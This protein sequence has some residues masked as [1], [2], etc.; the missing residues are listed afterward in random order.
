MTGNPGQL[1]LASGK[2]IQN[3]KAQAHEST[4]RKTCFT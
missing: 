2:N 4:F 3:T 1:T